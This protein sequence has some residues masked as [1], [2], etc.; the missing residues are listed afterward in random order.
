MALL[1]KQPILLTNSLE[2][3]KKIWHLP[4]SRPTGETKQVVLRQ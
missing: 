1:R 2:Q 4:T 3:K